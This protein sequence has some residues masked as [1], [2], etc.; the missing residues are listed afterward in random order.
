MLET[1]L[2]ASGIRPFRLGV[3]FDKLSQF[4]FAQIIALVCTV[5]TI[6]LMHSA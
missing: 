3:F 6:S 1:W 5:N 2:R 4:V